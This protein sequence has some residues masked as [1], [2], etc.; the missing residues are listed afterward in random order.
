MSIREAPDFT[1][2]DTQGRAVGLSSYRGKKRVVLV[3]TRG[4][5]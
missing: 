5:A 4:F 3:F 1:L 2:I